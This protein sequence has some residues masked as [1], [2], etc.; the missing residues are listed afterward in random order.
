M[1]KLPTTDTASTQHRVKPQ[2]Q[3]SKS[4]FLV[5]RVGPGWSWPAPRGCRRRWSGEAPSYAGAVTRF[6]VMV[7]PSESLNSYRLLVRFLSFGDS[8]Y[9]LSI[10]IRI[11]SGV[12]S[13][14][15]V[16]SVISVSLS[17]QSYS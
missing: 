8:I 3:E 9:L 16:P 10:D 4:R 14:F 13:S 5:E 7:L 11:Y 2:H 12:S 6:H 1:L 17:Y 15:Q